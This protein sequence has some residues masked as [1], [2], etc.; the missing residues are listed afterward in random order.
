MRRRRLRES[1]PGL[2]TARVAGGLARRCCSAPGPR[3][4]RA[5]SPPHPRGA[6]SA[7]GRL[8]DAI[9]NFAGASRFDRPSAAAPRSPR[10]PGASRKLAPMVEGR[11]LQRPLVGAARRAIGRRC[12]AYH[13]AT[14][15]FAS[16]FCGYGQRPPQPAL[17]GA[18]PTSP[19]AAVVPL[20]CA[21]YRGRRPVARAARP[22]LG[23]VVGSAGGGGLCAA[24]RSTRRPWRRPWRTWT[25]TRSRSSSRSSAPTIG[26]RGCGP[27]R[28]CRRSRRPAASRSRGPRS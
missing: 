9:G 19:G 27:S 1:K 11:L 20:W 2:H 12:H 17:S 16:A 21:G 26:P 15:C 25:L 6:A 10:T 13:R 4:H 5:S 24:R 14:G 8:R 28:A 3:T 18:A 23:P 22:R 7:V